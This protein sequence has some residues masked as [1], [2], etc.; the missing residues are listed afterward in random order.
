MKNPI[1]TLDLVSTAV[2]CFNRL[3]DAYETSKRIELEREQLEC[4]HDLDKR[5]LAIMERDLE[6]RHKQAIKAL[7]MR[8][9]ELTTK[10]SLLERSFGEYEAYMA[11][12]RDQS[13]LA[14]DRVCNGD[15][16]D[17]EFYL[18]LWLKVNET[19]N[20]RM[21]VQCE[22]LAQGMLEYNRE[23]A[24]LIGCAKTQKSAL[25]LELAKEVC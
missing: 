17:R 25:Q 1:A 20:R 11:Q 5:K 12:L 4:Q 9:R 6:R 16:K 23:V 7:A 22:S 14:M 24:N 3:V 8:D 15:E 19:G 13:K 10:L 18:G 2:G 21:A